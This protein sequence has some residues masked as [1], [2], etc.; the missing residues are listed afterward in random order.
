[1]LKR[2][3]FAEE[4]NLFR[5]GVR[6]FVEQEITPHHLQWE[7]DGVVP[8]DL[9]RKAGA[10]G[11]LCADVPELYGGPDCDF[12][13]NVVVTEELGRGGFTGPGFS[14]HS[15]MASTYVA[16]FGSEEQKQRWLPGMVT[17]D[18]ICAIAMTEPQAGSD[19]RGIRTRALRDGDDWVINGQ[20]VYISNGQLCDLIVVA[21]K[22]N[23]DDDGR[24]DAG[25][26]SLFLVEAEREGFARG[27][28][29]KKLGMKA[30]DTSE[31]FFQDVRI[32]AANMLGAEGQGMGYLTSNLARERLVQAVRS[33]AV[34]EA[35]LEWTVDYTAEREAFGRTI[36]S[37]QNTQFK[38][39]EVKTEIVSA[40]CFVDRCIELYMDGELGPVEAAMAKLKLAELQGWVVDQCLQFFGGA[41][42]MWEYP[43]TR[44]YADARVVRIAGGAVEVMKL[45]IGRDLFRD[46]LKK[47]S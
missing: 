46:R 23:P 21:A 39:A 28:N 33:A 2:T 29:L 38:L 35:V 25:G 26:I 17:G 11:L 16:N 43:I 36:G 10:A 8:R 22:T 4:H 42:Y 27:S 41:G 18:V 1:M 15:D 30:Q 45:I 24:G 6:K 9:W 3:L 20:K 14:V 34:I 32:P 7:D 47:P 13:F 12:L 44:A 40:R 5:D 31:M 19:L 37:F